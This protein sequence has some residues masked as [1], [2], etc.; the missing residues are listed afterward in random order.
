MKSYISRFIT[1]SICLPVLISVMASPIHALESMDDSEL[2]LTTGEGI[3]AVIDNLAIHSGDKYLPNGD[4]NTADGFEITIDLNES[5]GQE[6]FILSELRIHKRGTVSGNADSGGSFG[7]VANPVFLGDLRAV[8]LFT[9]TAS[10]PLDTTTTL[11]TVMRSAFPGASLSQLDRSTETQQKNLTRYES[12]LEKFNTELDKVSDEFN[13]H[14]RF[15]DVIGGGS[16]T[17]RNVIDAEGFRFYGTYSDVFSTAGSGLALAGATGIYIDKLTISTALP[18]DSSKAIAAAEL[19][20]FNRLLG[21]A[22]TAEYDAR[23]ATD[24]SALKNAAIEARKLSDAAPS[25]YVTTPEASQMILNG[26]D[27]YSVLGTKDQPLTLKSVQVDGKNQLQM[28]ISPLPASIG[29][30]PKSDIYIKSIY[31][32]DKYNEDLRTGV[33]D[34]SKAL[35]DP[36]RYHYAFQPEVGNTIEIRGM[37]IQ[38][39]RITTMDI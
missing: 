8:D 18:T 20:E 35:S 25:G 3:G 39:L 15:D 24:G 10:D 26:V 4:K 14:L 13:F 31:F 5:L 2:S 36:E 7:T 34:S 37:S 16:E 32:G 30:A 29:V 1:F 17:F 28:E 33:K 12:K 38:H 23:N 9:G 19:I 21:L 11:T 22:V 27:I 6:Q